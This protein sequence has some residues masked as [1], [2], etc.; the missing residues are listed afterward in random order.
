[1][2]KKLDMILELISAFDTAVELKEEMLAYL[3]S[4]ALFEASRVT[5]IAVIEKNGSFVVGNG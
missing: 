5:G 1:M 2:K 3:I 4:Q